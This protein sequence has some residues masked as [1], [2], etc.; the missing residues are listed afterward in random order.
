M[1]N[2]R[3]TETPKPCLKIQDFTAKSSKIPD[4]RKLTKKKLEDSSQMPLQDFEIE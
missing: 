3:L 1:I 2:L 4:S